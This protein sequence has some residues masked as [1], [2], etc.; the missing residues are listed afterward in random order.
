MAGPAAAWIIPSIIGLA[1]GI[2]GALNQPKQQTDPL[3]E[4]KQWRRPNMDIQRRNVTDTPL[5]GSGNV[6][7]GAGLMQQQP[8]GIDPNIM[9]MIKM[10]FGGMPGMGG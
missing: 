5:S 1:Q 10:L 4:W 7:A 8:Q 2:Y 9:N 3:A 6:R